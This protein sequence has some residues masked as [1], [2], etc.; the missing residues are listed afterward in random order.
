MTS[1]V[2]GVVDIP[3]VEGESISDQRKRAGKSR[4]ARRVKFTVQST[5]DVAQILEAKYGVMQAFYKRHGDDIA[6]ICEQNMSE[7]LEDLMSTGHI[8]KSLFAG[9]ESQIETLFRQFLS[10]SEIESMGIQGVPTQAA[11]DGVNHRKKHA[12]SKKNARRPSF[13]DTGLYEASF[14]VEVK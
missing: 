5:G 13:I 12:Y 11:L 4:K 10:R 9:S 3:Y 1:L 14:A 6:K 7:A 2:F 8:Q